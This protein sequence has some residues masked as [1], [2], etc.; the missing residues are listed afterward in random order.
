MIGSNRSRW[1][2]STVAMMG[3]VVTMLLP[4]PVAAQ[5]T[6]GAKA[7][8]PVTFAKDVARFCRRNVRSVIILERWRRCR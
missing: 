7:T 1:V 5:S 8:R 3:G 2:A 6:A 4:L